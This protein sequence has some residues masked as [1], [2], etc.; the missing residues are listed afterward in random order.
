MTLQT[1]PPK[2]VIAFINE[3]SPGGCPHQNR[4][5]NLRLRQLASVKKVGARALWQTFYLILA[6][7]TRISF[8]LSKF[9]PLAF[10]H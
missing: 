10:E 9:W 5:S 6:Q 4:E 8:M 7:W 1:R 2:I 3:L